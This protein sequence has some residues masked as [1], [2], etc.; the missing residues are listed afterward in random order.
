MALVNQPERALNAFAEAGGDVLLTGHAHIA[1]A[2]IHDSAE[3]RPIIVTAAGTAASTRLRGELPSYNL[4]SWD[5]RELK[6]GIHRYS[7]NG[8][9]TD[10]EKTFVRHNEIWT[11][12]ETQ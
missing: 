7:S 1:Q 11:K 3:H 8:Y 6:V 5:G 12:T 2:E 10:F 4:L 9:A